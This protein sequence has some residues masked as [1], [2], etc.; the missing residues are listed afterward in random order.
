MHVGFCHQRKAFWSTR[1]HN[2]F[3]ASLEKH[4]ELR[5]GDAKLKTKM[6]PSDAVLGQNSREMHLK[7]H[8]TPKYIFQRCFAVHRLGV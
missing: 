2:D 5:P 3:D 1:V 6:S 4:L 7:H 8:S